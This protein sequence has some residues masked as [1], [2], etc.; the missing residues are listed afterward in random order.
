ML[1]IGYPLSPMVGFALGYYTAS[2]AQ[3]AA[4]LRVMAEAYTAVHKMLFS[5]AYALL[6]VDM[7][8]RRRRRAE[9]GDFV[10][11]ARLHSAVR[12][13]GQLHVFGAGRGSPC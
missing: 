10:Q 7:P 1:S 3:Y 13:R 8:L 6:L 11:R 2:I 9:G 12:R 5:V 4:D